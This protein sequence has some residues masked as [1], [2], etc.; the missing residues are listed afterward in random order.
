MPSIGSRAP[1]FFLTLIMNVENRSKRHIKRQNDIIQV[2]RKNK[3]T[4]TLEHYRHR[5][6]D[7]TLETIDSVA[8]QLGYHPFNIVNVVLSNCQEINGTDNYP[9]VAILYP[10]NHND[11]VGGRYSG[12]DGPKPFPTTLWI[13]CPD[14][15]TRIS[16]LEGLGY[17]NKLQHKLLSDLG[18]EVWLQ[19]MRN[20]HLEYA[21]FRWDL[22][23]PDDMNL[24]ESSGW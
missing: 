11:E 1:R 9:L 22:L 4:P 10:L 15:H 17:I 3:V 13:T 12:K 20:A 2:N 19:Q 18:C 16:R 14:L 7:L 24:V 23:G 21:A 6:A 8:G 5:G